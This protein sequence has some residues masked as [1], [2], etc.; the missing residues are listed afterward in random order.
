VSSAEHRVKGTLFV[1]YVRMLRARSDVDWSKWLQPIDLGYLVQRIDPAAWYP[2]ETFERMGLAILAE[3]AQGQLEAVRMFGRASV[4][5]LS[6]TYGTLVASGDPRDTLMRFQVL[7]RSFFDY[8]ALEIG[9]ICDGEASIL[10]GYEM[11]PRAEEAAC[12][13][14]LGFLER[15]LEM[16]GAND[17]RA[18]FASR[19]WTGDLVTT[20]ELRWK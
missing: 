13:Q 11:G 5:W 17:V 20:V 19:A 3:V 2:M 8:S 4:D 1:D 9:S 7:R 10:V 12:W 15:L 14:T 18:W 16:A 6:Q